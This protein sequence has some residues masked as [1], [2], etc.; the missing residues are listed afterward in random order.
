MKKTAKKTVL[1][2]TTGGVACE[3]RAVLDCKLHHYTHQIVIAK[4]AES[5]LSTKFQLSEKGTRRVKIVDT[6]LDRGL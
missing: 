6:E 2:K 5:E 3:A 4:P 1:K